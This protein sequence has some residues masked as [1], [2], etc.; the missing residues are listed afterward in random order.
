MGQNKHAGQ[1]FN[2]LKAK[3]ALSI[4]FL[5]ASLTTRHQGGMTILGLFEISRRPVDAAL[6]IFCQTTDQ[7][8]LAI[9]K[10]GQRQLDVLRN[11]F[12]FGRAL[13][14]DVV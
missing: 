12:D 8:V 3:R 5:T 2:A 1:P 9:E 14:T 4:K 11:A 6:R 10:L 7:L 13:A